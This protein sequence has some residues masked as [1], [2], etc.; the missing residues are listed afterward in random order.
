MAPMIE[1]HNGA[2]G[3][4]HTSKSVPQLYT[5]VNQEQLQKDAEKYLA[6]YGTKFEKPVFTGS[7]GLYVYTADGRAVLDWTSGQMS[8]LIGHGHPEIGKTT[9]LIC[10]GP[11]FYS[12]D[13]SQTRS[14]PGPSVFRH[15][16]AS[17]HQPCEEIDLGP[18]SRTRQSFFFEH[19]R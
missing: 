19:G 4:S 8:C 16:L 11:D 9:Q 7:Q 12:R 13:Y 2:N 6:N 15:G 10:P 14:Q 17:R 18:T 1:D 3:Q 5:K